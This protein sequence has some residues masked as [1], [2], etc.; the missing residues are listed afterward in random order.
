MINLRWLLIGLIAGNLIGISLMEMKINW[1]SFIIS[2]VFIIILMT[3]DILE[4][5]KKKK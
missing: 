5:R 3:I 2:I 4:D 1:A